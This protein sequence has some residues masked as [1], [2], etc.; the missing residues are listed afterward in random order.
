MGFLSKLFGGAS[1]APS[2]PAPYQEPVHNDSPSGFSWGENMPDEENQFNYNGTFWEYFENIFRSDFSH[3]RF[4]KKELNPSKRFVYTFYSGEA[5]VLVVELMS[6]SC[7]AYMYR[8]DCERSGI[9]YRR[10]YHDHDGWWNTSSNVCRMHLCHRWLLCQQTKGERF[11]P[12]ADPARQI[13]KTS[14]AVLSRTA[15]YIQ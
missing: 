14:Q 5:I 3:L 13:I 2:A 15:R 4:E 11:A 10:F 1:S 6:Q 7:A 12:V 8:N 9:P